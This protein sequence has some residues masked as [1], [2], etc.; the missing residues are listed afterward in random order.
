MLQGLVVGLSVVISFIL[1]A[2]TILVL[3][4]TFLSWVDPSPYNKVVVII[5]K[6]TEPMYR[7]FRRFVGS[8]GGVIDLSPMIVLLIVIF[9]KSAIPHFLQS[10][11]R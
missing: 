9:L 1:D 10:L 11:I 8:V 5:R 3:A 4:S 7:P 6:L 2:I